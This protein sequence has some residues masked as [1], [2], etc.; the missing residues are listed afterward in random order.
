MTRTGCDIKLQKLIKEWQGF[1]KNINRNSQ[2]E[3]QKRENYGV[4]LDKLFDLSSRDWEQ[5]IKS[6]RNSDAATYIN[7][8][9]VLFG[10]RCL[11]PLKAKII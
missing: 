7:L 2:T 5:Q 3:L 6:S 1:K 11:D 4:S 8:F 10:L 9:L